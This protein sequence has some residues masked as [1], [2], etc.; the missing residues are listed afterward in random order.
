[1]SAS[2][3]GRLR[4]RRLRKGRLGKGGFGKRKYLISGIKPPGFS[5]VFKPNVTTAVPLV[6]Q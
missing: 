4:N 2:M 6:I 1:M 3:L 5:I